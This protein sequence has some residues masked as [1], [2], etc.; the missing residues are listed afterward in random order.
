MFPTDL[1]TILAISLALVSLVSAIYAVFVARKALAYG[2]SLQKWAH[3]D[4]KTWVEDNSDVSSK[5]QI[6]EL[7]A[8]QAEVSDSLD[9]LQTSVRKLRN[10][11]N[12]RDLRKRRELAD[13]EDFDPVNTRDKAALRKHLRDTGQIR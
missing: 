6:A 9:A 8:G 13:D 7:V 10:R 12:M 1:P 3:S 2:L 11:K 4:L 5:R